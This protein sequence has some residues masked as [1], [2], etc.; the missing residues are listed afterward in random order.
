VVLEER[1]TMKFRFPEVERSGRDVAKLEGVHKR[2]GAHVI[3]DGLSATVERGQRIAVIGANGAGKT[4]LLKLLAGELAPDSGTVSL[5]H[6]VVLG[7]YAQHHAEKLDRTKTILEEVRPLAA[8][9]P[10]SHVRG[11]LGAFLFSGDD[12][13]KPIGV[14]SGGERAR[15]ALAKLLLQPSNFLLMDEPTNHL[16]LDSS[17]MLIEA[18]Q[19]YTGTLLFVSHTRSFVN[20]LA[21]HVWDVAGG[22]VIPHPGNLDDYLYHQEQRRLAEEAASA[23]AEAERGGS[24]AAGSGPVSEKERKR[25]E[26]EARQRLSTVAGPLKK[27][28]SAVEAR[29]AALEAEQKER[30]AALAD[31]ALY[32]DFARAK[33]LMDAHREGKETLEALYAQWERAQEKLAEVSASLG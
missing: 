32:D 28:I 21:S 15:V 2:Y 31:P 13:E 18:L 8:D 22:K 10:E 20:G 9:K 23:G 12:V 17:E 5:G 29:I 27:E 6:N 19:G 3:Y 14:L 25:L 4:T 26:A 24:K 16:D 33:P 30:E 11:V 7:Y 1:Q